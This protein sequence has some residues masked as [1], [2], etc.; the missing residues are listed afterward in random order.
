[1]KHTKK[2]LQYVYVNSSPQDSLISSIIFISYYMLFESDTIRVLSLGTCHLRSC[3]LTNLVSV[4]G[5]P[6]ASDPRTVYIFP[7]PMI[8]LSQFENSCSS[9]PLF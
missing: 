6:L 7:K 2:Y 5:L 9:H 4:F 8:S 1:M 3:P